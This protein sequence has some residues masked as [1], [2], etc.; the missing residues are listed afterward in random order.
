MEIAFD[1]IREASIRV[2]SPIGSTLGIIGGLI[3]GQAAVS[4]NLV[5]PIA[6]IIVAITGIG[7]FA[8]PNYALNFS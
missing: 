1:I 4:A 3:V 6:I 7:S 8:T 5:S 2:P